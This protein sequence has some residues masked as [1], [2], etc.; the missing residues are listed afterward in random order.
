[1]TQTVDGGKGDDV[2]SVDYS[3]AAGGI[4]TTFNATTNIGEITAGKNRVSYKNIEGL[5]ILGTAYNDN[6]VGNSGNDT[7]SGG[8]GKD[9]I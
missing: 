2:L 1:M 3:N 4:T 5:N 8:Y 6:I 9:T 7:L